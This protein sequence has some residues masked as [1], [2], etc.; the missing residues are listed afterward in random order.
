MNNIDELD[1]ELH[2]LTSDDTPRESESLKWHKFGKDMYCLNQLKLGEAYL[3]PC[4][5][6]SR[7]ISI[8]IIV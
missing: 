5:D 6:N 7:V 3:M 4:H 8:A 1:N 2:I